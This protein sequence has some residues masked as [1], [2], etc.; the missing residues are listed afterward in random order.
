MA[1]NIWMRGERK[2]GRGGGGRKK[3]PNRGVGKTPEPPVEVALSS[4]LL[5]GRTRSPPAFASSEACPCIQLRALCSPPGEGT[6]R[7]VCACVTL[8]RRAQTPHHRDRLCFVKRKK[9]KR[10]F[11]SPRRPRCF[12]VDGWERGFSGALPTGSA[13][14]LGNTAGTESALSTTWPEICSLVYVSIT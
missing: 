12:P 9:Q 7:E 11:F 13:P 14:W 3:S 5:C 4:C 2:P 1:G 8:P 10:C 6:G